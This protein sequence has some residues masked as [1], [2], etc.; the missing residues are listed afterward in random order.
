M[1]AFV[2]LGVVWAV[3][4]GVQLRLMGGNRQRP[5]EEHTAELLSCEP[6]VVHA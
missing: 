1:A 3:G 2:C 6:V 4:V 5:R